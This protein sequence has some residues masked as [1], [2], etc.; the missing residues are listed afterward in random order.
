MRHVRFQDPG[1]GLRGKLPLLF[2]DL[3][4]DGGDV[5]PPHP[6]ESELER[7]GPRDLHLVLAGHT[8]R[9]GRAE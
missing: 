3:R 8:R 5:A 2:A 1:V 6:S 7:V 9:R 4:V